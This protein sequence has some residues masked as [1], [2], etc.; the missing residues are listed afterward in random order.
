VFDSVEVK[1]IHVPFK[2]PLVADYMLP[3]SPLPDASFPF[4]RAAGRNSFSAW[5]RSGEPSLDQ[6]PAYG[7]VGL[8]FRQTPDAMKMI[9]QDHDAFDDKW[10]PGTH[11]P[12]RL[13]QLGNMPNQQIVVPALCQIH[14][15][16]IAPTGNSCAGVGSHRRRISWD[17]TSLHPSL[18][19]CMR[20][21]RLAHEQR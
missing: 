5:Q 16:E 15:E 8:A 13:A 1:I 9:R 20:S 11:A 6:S 7:E 17:S 18:P 4:A 12:E 21:A 3:I 2:I 19:G 14:R 10:I